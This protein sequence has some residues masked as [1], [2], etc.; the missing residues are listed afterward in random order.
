MLFVPYL[1]IGDLTDKLYGGEGTDRTHQGGYFF[2]LDDIIFNKPEK[3]QVFKFRQQV[4][5]VVLVVV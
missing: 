4:F 1:F 5:A 2:I 3:I